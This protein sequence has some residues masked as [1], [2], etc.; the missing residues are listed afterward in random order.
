L[1]SELDFVPLTED[2]IPQVVDIHS[3]AFAGQ[4]N[5]RLGK[6]YLFYFFKWFIN[7][8][9]PISIVAI[10]NGKYVRGYVIGA[11]LGYEIALNRDLFWVTAGCIIS[12]PSLWFM[13]N[14]RGAVIGRLKILV[15]LPQTK[16][17]YPQLPSPVASLVGI[18]VA[19][20]Y[21]KWGI[22]NQLMQIF[23][24]KSKLMQMKSMRLSVYPDNQG[25]RHLYEKCGWS[26]FSNV[27]SSGKA[28]FYYKL[29]TSS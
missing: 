17:Q 12:R 14:I 16:V 7:Y 13:Q 26:A 18:G 11:P 4:M 27:A 23:E 9:Y 3:Q 1:H 5:V 20:H 28:M 8:P 10:E 29:I 2:F 15:G 19:P 21:Q 24:E 25:A 22:G 6:K